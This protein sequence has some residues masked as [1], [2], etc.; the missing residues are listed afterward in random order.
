MTGAAPKR[1]SVPRIW[2]QSVNRRADVFG[3]NFPDL[4]RR[5][6]HL[7]DNILRGTKLAEI[8]VAEVQ[9]WVQI[10][11]AADPTM[12]GSKYSPAAIRE[13]WQKEGKLRWDGRT[14][15]GATAC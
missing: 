1:G 10:W 14:H 13:V 8:P 11:A 15:G 9:T 2:H 7:V 5:A 3:T 12:S 6:A 4:F